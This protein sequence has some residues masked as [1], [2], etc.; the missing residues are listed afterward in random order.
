MGTTTKPFP[1]EFRAEIPDSIETKLQR[2]QPDFLDR[3]GFIFLLLS[4]ALDTL[5]SGV[6]IPAYRVGAGERALQLNQPSLQQPSPLTGSEA[7]ASE[8]AVPPSDIYEKPTLGSGLEKGE[9]EGK[10]DKGGSSKS[11]LKP[12]TDSLRQHEP[13][14]REFWSCKKGSKNAQAW[15]LLLTELEKIQ[16]QFGD[17]RTA[18]QLTL[19]INGLWKG[20]TLRNLQ[21]FEQAK[22]TP[23]WQKEPETQHPA[24][25]SAKEVLAEQEACQQ[26]EHERQRQQRLKDQEIPSVTGGRGVLEHLGF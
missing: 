2:H 23:T 22:P 6:T 20:I 12:V 11:K 25:R 26:R 13:L 16:K 24:Y 18:E 17:E 14:I 10:E 5:D 21:R 15:S 7:S 4:Q 8:V 19:A 9:S 1:L 3:K